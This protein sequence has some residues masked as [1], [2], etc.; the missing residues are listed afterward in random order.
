M[1]T[2][3][4]DVQD[5]SPDLQDV[6]VI[7]S[8]KIER[9]NELCPELLAIHSLNFA[10]AYNAPAR[11]TMMSSHFSQRPVISGSEPD[12]IQTGVAEE[13]GKYTFNVKMPEDGIILRKIDRYKSKVDS[14]I[15]HFNPESTV[16]YRSNET[17]IVDYFTLPYYASY[18][19]T[20]GFQY[21]HKEAAR[22]ITY[23]AE[24]QKDTIF[25]D[26]PAVKGESH[27]T[28]GRNLN[29][30]FMSHPNVGLD[31]YVISRDVLEHFKFKIYETRSVSLSAAFIPINLYGDETKYKA[32]PDIGEYVREDGLLMARRPYDPNLAPALFSKDDLREVDYLFD[33][34]V[35]VRAG[36]GRVV[37]LSV[38]K[39][40][41]TS[42]QLPKEVT[43]HM[44]HYAQR[45]REYYTELTRLEEQLTREANQHG[46]ELQIS[47]A[48]QRLLVTAKAITGY[49]H[50]QTKAPITLTHKREPLD[51]WRL[52]FVIE[53]EITPTKGFKLSCQNGGFK[54]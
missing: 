7:T 29:V 46:T 13:F 34:K 40:E 24:F 1:D 3:E 48:L 44:D 43:E 47:P 32:F 21:E 27:Y 20:F 53:Y 4:T 41:G 19:S 42:R 28:Y 37:D 33:D 6:D 10:V 45:N 30:I 14:P 39:T 15:P 35:Y 38:I 51:T 25:A 16:I 2:F 23:N 22:H 26:S 9:V 49:R 5:E 11:G 54:I 17:G 31:G 36:R 8:G 18:H 52:T 50:S 12:L